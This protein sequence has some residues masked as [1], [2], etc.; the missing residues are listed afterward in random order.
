MLKKLFGTDG[1]RGIANQEPVTAEIALKLGRALAFV[2]Q[3]APNKQISRPK[4]LIGKDT[5]ISGYMLEF[6]LASGIC[7]MGADVLL[8]GPIPT[9]GVAFLTVNMRCDTG[10]VISASHN[11][12]EDNGIKFFSGDG[13]K[14]SERN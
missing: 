7:S 11:P 2:T 1:V 14:L 9:P 4:I 10:A 12:H 3:S 5:R 8:A 13:Y 6:A